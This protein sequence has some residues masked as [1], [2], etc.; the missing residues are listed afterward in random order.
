MY[1]IAHDARA[2]KSAALLMNATIALANQKPFNE[3]SISELQR[4]SSVSRSTFYR[5]FDTPV[6][7]LAY[8]CEQM[9]TE[10]E[11]AMSQATV[12]DVHDRILLFI[13]LCMQRVDLLQALV[14][15]QQTELLRV[16][17]HQHMASMMASVQIHQAVQ[18]DTIDYI[19]NIMAD[20]LPSAMF[21]WLAHG[22]KEDAKTVYQQIR[23]SVEVLSNLYQ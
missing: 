17:H 6:D 22:R 9:A 3:I 7:V 4:L 10:I 13:E 14:V 1:H 16:A 11:E 23:T 2:K 21:V 12:I 5:L 15:S 19:N 20:I 8:A 18:A